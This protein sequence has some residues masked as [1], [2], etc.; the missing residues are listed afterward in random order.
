MMTENSKDA[1]KNNK[2][3]GI[4][5]CV[6]AELLNTVGCS[7]ETKC[8]TY[9]Q[10]F[11]NVSQRVSIDKFKIFIHVALSCKDPANFIIPP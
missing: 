5:C 9:T 7:L 11:T 10:R 6:V 2:S 3:P 8:I 4:N 1:L